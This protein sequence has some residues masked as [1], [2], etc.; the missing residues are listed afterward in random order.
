M[1]FNNAFWS[2]FYLG[3]PVGFSGKTGN[4]SDKWS[5]TQGALKLPKKLNLPNETGLVIFLQMDIGTK[6]EKRETTRTKNCVLTR[7]LHTS[8]SLLIMTFSDLGGPE[9]GRCVV[10]VVVL[11]GY[12]EHLSS[13]SLSCC[14]PT[15]SSIS[16]SC[17]LPTLWS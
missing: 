17:C 1:E 7:C 5:F 2:E 11:S 9:K 15:L 10:V 6:E 16:L 14:L 12:V 13:I 3:L 8:V 4:I